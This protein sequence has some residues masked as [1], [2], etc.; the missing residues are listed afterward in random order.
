M[1][2]IKK[3]NHDNDLD[4]QVRPCSVHMMQDD[5]IVLCSYLFLLNYNVTFFSN[6][7]S[8][9]IRCHAL[10]WV[11]VKRVSEF[12][13]LLFHHIGHIHILTLPFSALNNTQRRISVFDKQISIEWIYFKIVNNAWPPIM[14]PVLVIDTEICVQWN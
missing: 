8:A 12:L 3:M 5:N 2:I 1:W 4:I 6:T 11:I 10:H 7:E 14:T 9:L 13:P